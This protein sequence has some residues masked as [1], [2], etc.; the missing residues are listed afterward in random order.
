M[1]LTNI[2][3]LSPKCNLPKGKARLW[4]ISR[5]DKFRTHEISMPTGDVSHLYSICMWDFMVH[6]FMNMNIC[7]KKILFHFLG[8]SLRGQVAQDCPWS[9]SSWP[10][11]MMPKNSTTDHL[12]CTKCCPKCFT[13]GVSFKP[14][15]SPKKWVSLS[16]PWDR[17]QRL[18]LVK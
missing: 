4:Y 17:W 16:S 8:S 9:A 6:I 13:W 5:K 11:T 10:S 7:G 18:K 1:V 2:K 12:L 14:C 15:N 3:H